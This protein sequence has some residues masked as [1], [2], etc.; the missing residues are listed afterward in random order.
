MSR[1]FL[2]GLGALVVML[3]PGSVLDVTGAAQSRTAASDTERQDAERKLIREVADSLKK[4]AASASTAVPKNWKASRT[5]WGD[6][7]IAGVYTNSDESG[8][9]FERPAE[10]DGRR[11]EDIT[12][13]E[14]ATAPADATGCDCRKRGAAGGLS[15]I[16]SCSGGRR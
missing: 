12:G 1:R 6:P 11:L 4:K 16:P 5:P 8:I 14:L 15:R 9:P 3:A 13:A 7:D 10:F 2:V